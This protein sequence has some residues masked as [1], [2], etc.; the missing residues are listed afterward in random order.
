MIRK[1]KV[2]III[3]IILIAYTFIIGCATGNECRTV[4]LPGK[5]CATVC[6]PLSEW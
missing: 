3:S 1:N 6:K 2:A 4:C 5:D